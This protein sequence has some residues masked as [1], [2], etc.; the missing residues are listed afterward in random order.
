[1]AWGCFSP[2]QLSESAWVGKGLNYPGVE[3][4]VAIRA[5]WERPAIKHVGPSDP[6]LGPGCLCVIA[7]GRGGMLASPGPPGPRRRK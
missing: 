1:M 5:W 7:K 4:G 2:S 3:H 6:A